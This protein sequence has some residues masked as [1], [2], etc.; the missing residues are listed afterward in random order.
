MA[1][2]WS[3]RLLLSGALCSLASPKVLYAIAGAW[4]DRPIKIIVGFPA[5]GQADVYARMY[6]EFIALETGVPVV[7][8]NKAGA[9][10]SIAATEVKLARPDGYTLLFSTSG[11]FSVNRVLVKDLSYAESDFELVAAMPTGGL[12]LV[13]SKGVA[14]KELSEFVKFAR[15]ADRV[16]LG[17][18]GVGSPA[19]LMILAM[20]EQFNL[21]IEPAHY[22]GEGPMWNDVASQNIDGGIGSILGARPVLE[23]GKGTAVA[24]PRKRLISLPEVKTFAEQGAD[25]PLFELMTYFCCAVPTGTPTAVVERLS[26]LIVRA[27]ASAKVRTVLATFGIDEGPMSIEATRELY[28]R[29]SPVWVDLA[30]RAVP[31]RKN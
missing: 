13:V 7:I 11:A 16:T 2:A 30:Q 9:L 29:E 5:G 27:G 25:A 12:P 23:A 20:N 18:F 19:H 10:G 3:R 22:R 17:T 1:M 28:A 31:S 15:A 8:E 4:P 26:D 14:A 21:S 6:A 24:V